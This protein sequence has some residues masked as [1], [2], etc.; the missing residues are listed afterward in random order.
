MATVYEILGCSETATADELKAAYKRAAFDAHPDRGGDAERFALIQ[1]A[2]GLVSEPAE[3][4][5]YDARLAKKRAPK[6]FTPPSPPFRITVDQ[7]LANLR[8][9][10]ATNAEMRNMPGVPQGFFDIT[11][12]RLE[13]VENIVIGVSKVFGGS[14]KKP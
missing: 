4:A 6:D 3:R 11:T 13:G 5:R 2:W 7:L 10:Q 12:E 8:A 9:M 14:Q 1:R